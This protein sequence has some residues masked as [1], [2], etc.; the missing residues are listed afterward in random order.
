MAIETNG[1]PAIAT[2]LWNGTTWE[3]WNG[4]PTPPDAN[5]G[6]SVYD[7]RRKTI[8]TIH[9]DGRV[10]EWDPSTGWHDRTS[11]PRPPKRG[12][13]GSL[14]YDAARGRVVMFGGYE[15]NAQKYLDDTWEW[16]GSRWHQANP[17]VRPSPRTKHVMAYASW[18]G[19]VV[20]VAGEF[21]APPKW[22]KNYYTDMWL[23][24]G[25]QWARLGS[26]GFPFV[27]RSY[28]EYYL[29][30]GAVPTDLVADIGRE[31]LRLFFGNS[32]GWDSLA[33]DL[34]PRPLSTDL[35]LPR[36]GEQVRFDIALPH[37]PSRPFAMLLSGAAGPGIPLFD[38]GGLGPRRL[39]L[40]WDPL[41]AA[42]LQLGLV[43]TLDAQ[44][45]G[46]WTLPI[47]QDLGL[48]G[49]R[50]HAAG[51][52]LAPGPAFGSITNRVQLDIVR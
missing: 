11:D 30:S 39:P 4:G 20:L 29:A 47:P 38:T 25:T 5:M 33:W 15:G 12:S 50:I 43:Q 26:G 35:V 49:T 36:P 18:L 24:D 21:A 44:G 37:D 13:M 14:A 34:E 32:A 27:S 40:G 22:I 42:S 48:V 16:D 6:R 41:L 52:T 51:L 28:P 1:G 23:W 19:G 8:V 31:R 9:T 17:S 45:R 3:R 7:S 10:L 2:R 46:A